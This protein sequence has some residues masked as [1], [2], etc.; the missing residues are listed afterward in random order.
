MDSFN[1]GNIIVDD[2]G[3][4]RRSL[5]LIGKGFRFSW[6]E[7]ISWK[8]SQSLLPSTDTGK[9]EPISI[10]LELNGPTGAESVDRRTAGDMLDALVAYLRLRCPDKE[11]KSESEPASAT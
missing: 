2:D 7:L 3:I 10:L 8:S 4:R 1:Y 11:T 6:D 9:P 5:P